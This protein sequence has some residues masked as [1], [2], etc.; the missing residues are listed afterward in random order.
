M[1]LNLVYFLPKVKHL[2]K[3][4][5]S[6]SLCRLRYYI[7]FLPQFHLDGN[8]GR[9]MEDVVDRNVPHPD[10]MGGELQSFLY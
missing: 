9:E 6:L 4:V 3:G 10:G 7:Y 1:C 5:I 8:G 2:V